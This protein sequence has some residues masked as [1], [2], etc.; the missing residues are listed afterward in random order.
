MDKSDP[1]AYFARMTADLPKRYQARLNKPS[2]YKVTVL[3]T[4]SRERALH[5]RMNGRLDEVAA[6]TFP[7]GHTKSANAPR[8]KVTG[9]SAGGHVLGAS[10][11][12]TH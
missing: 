12:D 8:S 11:E 4:V 9:I 3:P 6:A 2:A 7:K 5:G 1:T 10:Y